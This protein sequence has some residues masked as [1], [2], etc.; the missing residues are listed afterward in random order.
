LSGTWIGRNY[1]QAFFKEEERKGFLGKGSH[2][3]PRKKW[4]EYSKND[5][6]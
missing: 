2:L 5:L 3:K 6:K 1:I 4:E